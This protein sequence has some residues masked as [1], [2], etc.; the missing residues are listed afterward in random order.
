MLIPQPQAGGISYILFSNNF[1]IL[2][3]EI[4]SVNLNESN[5]EDSRYTPLGKSLNY[6]GILDV[7]DR[8][9]HLIGISVKV[10]DNVESKYTDNVIDV[11]DNSGR[12]LIECNDVVIGN[13]VI[14]RNNRGYNEEGIKVYNTDTPGMLG[15]DRG[16]IVLRVIDYPKSLTERTVV[17]VKE[18]EIEDED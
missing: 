12:V 8:Y 13:S 17:S 15:I 11:R 18:V 1:N 3:M 14:L 6:V 9:E 10:R 16:V 7:I 2:D 4:R 5:I